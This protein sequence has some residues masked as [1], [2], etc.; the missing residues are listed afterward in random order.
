MGFGVPAAIGA[1]LGKPDAL[2]VSINGDGGFQMNIQELV[3]AVEHRLPVNF[4]VLNNGHLGNVRQWQEMFYNKRYV[5]TNLT[6]NGRSENEGVVDPGEPVYLPDFVKVA[7]AYGAKA[8]RVFSLEEVEK[9]LAEAF[10]SKEPW[11]IECIVAPDE[12]VLP[13]V[14]PGSALSDMIQLSTEA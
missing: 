5:A 9:T 14:P 3:V 11:V 13:I 4:I 2:V 1:Q 6:Q 7:E 12:N 10:A 8:R